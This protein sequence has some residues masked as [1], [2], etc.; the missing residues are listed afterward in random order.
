M[1]NNLR[2]S[3][4]DDK[5]TRPTKV[6]VSIKNAMYNISKIQEF[7]GNNITIMPV[8]K[9]NA[10]GSYL[11][12]RL[13]FLNNFNIV[14]VAIV[15]EGVFLRK[16]GYKKD[17][18]VLNQPDTEEIE[19][20][21]DNNLI[22]GI[23]SDHFVDDLGKFKEEVKVHIEIGTGMGRTGVHPKRTE[24]YIDKIKKYPNIIIDG[25]YTHLSSADIDPEYTKKQLKSFDIAVEIAKSKV[26]TIR[27]IHSESST[28]IL[29]FNDEKYNL[30]RPGLIIYGYYPDD[31]FKS[32]IDLKPVIT[33]FY[34]KITLLK[35]VPENF[36]IG[37][38]RSFI[39]KRKTK[40]A[41][42]PVRICRWI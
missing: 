38:G 26:S 3:F 27:Y 10:Y 19:K 18:F 30:V 31:S 15:D 35:E 32:K 11:N 9:A 4:K 12:E 34:S 16:I 6:D 14:A 17:I 28:G 1:N 29:N 8:I 7:V 13:D 37:Y 21:I 2:S 40:V 36:S 24:E 5:I 33:K 23:S 41:T 42:I 20:I 39:T 22:V 25:I